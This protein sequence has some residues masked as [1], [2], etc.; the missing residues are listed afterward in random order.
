MVFDAAAADHHG[1]AQNPR[2][3]LEIAIARFSYVS[4]CGMSFQSRS[5]GT[6]GKRGTRL[7]CCAYAVFMARFD[8]GTCPA[9]GIP[10]QYQH[11][12]SAIS[13]Y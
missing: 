10:S 1:V 11:L 12:T 4:Y 3:D 8:V 6:R 9:S 13:K 5:F 7:Q 2:S